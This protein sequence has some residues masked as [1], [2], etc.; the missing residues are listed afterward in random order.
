[1]TPIEQPHERQTYDSTFSLRIIVLWMVFVAIVF[2]GASGAIFYFYHS[3]LRS[4]GT[5]EEFITSWMMTLVLGY[6]YNRMLLHVASH[7]LLKKHSRSFA[8]L[9]QPMQDDCTYMLID[10]WSAFY[11]IPLCIYGCHQV[12]Y[13][14]DN[15]LFFQEIGPLAKVLHVMFQVDRVLQLIN[16]FRM[17]RLAHHA[18]V[19]F[20]TLWVM[21]WSTSTRYGTSTS[22][23]E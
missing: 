13:I 22:L 23:Q 14:D 19:T 21:E 20:W 18:G 6:A 15:E 9:S 12:F 17:D 2:G 11:W 4:R 16:H 8:M 3:M 5:Q 10:T 7:K 1:M